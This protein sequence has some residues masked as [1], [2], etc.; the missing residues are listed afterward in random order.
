MAKKKKHFKA[1]KFIF[2][3]MAIVVA[4]LLF[5]T[6]NHFYNKIINNKVD[7]YLASN[8]SQVDLYNQEFKKITTTSRGQ[9]V[10]IEKDKSVKDEN[11]KIFYEVVIDDHLY[12]VATDNLTENRKDVVMEEKIYARTATNL[13]KDLDSGELL[14][15]V[16]K[17]EELTVLDY[18]TININGMVNMYKVQYN[19]QEGYINAKYIEFTKEAALAHYEPEKYYNIHAKRGN[20]YGGGSAANLDY[21]P[22]IKPVFEDNKMPDP[23]YALYLNSGVIN[24]VDA[25]IRLAENT[26]INAFVVDIKDNEAPGYKSEVM[27]QYS[28]TN[29]NKARNSLE[30][31]KTAIKKLKDAGFYVIGRITVFKDLYYATDHPEYAI[32]DTRTGQ[33]YLHSGTY[34]PSPYQRDVW[35]FNVNLAKEAVRE[36]GF[37]EIQFDYVRFPDRTVAAE[38]QGLMNFRNTYGEEKA[39]AVQRFLMYACDELHKLKVYVAADVFGESAHTYVTAYGQY[40]PAITNVVD[41]ISGMPYPNHFNKYEYGFKVPVWTVP[42]DL[43][44]YWGKTYVMK[45]QQEVPTPAIV[46]TWV[47]AFD[48]YQG[49]DPYV[50]YNAPEVEAEIRGLFDAGLTGGYMTWNAG[51]NIEKYRAQLAAYSKDYK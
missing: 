45:R 15:L 26:K 19:G 3:I 1:S 44:N 13:L 17:G 27:R 4:Y 21:Y 49:V 16:K 2:F 36:M 41:V 47:A 7:M 8:I 25:Y 23:V 9:K 37:N 24:N 39:Q 51:S 30:V 40:W 14:G 50:P 5:N 42:Y 12:Y 33:P 18:D 35:E 22:V 10:V 32:Y 38:K 34:W 48:T 46:R 20:S 28:I 11:N 6:F 43:L 29:Y 31:Y